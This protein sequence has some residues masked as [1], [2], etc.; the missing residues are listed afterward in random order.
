MKKTVSLLIL[1]FIIVAPLSS[2]RAGQI[3]SPPAQPRL[4]V[5]DAYSMIAAVNALRAAN[6][7]PA[8]TVNTTLMSLAQAH[9]DYMAA[10]GQVVHTDAGGLRPY[11]RALAAGYPLA[12]DL[13]L[14]GFY[15]ENIIMGQD[16]SV[17]DAVEAWQ[18]DTPHL[19]TM[20]APGLLEIGAGVSIVGGS[21]YYD[22]D[23]ARPTGSGQPQSYT[24]VAGQATEVPLNGTAVF[25]P[26]L[27]RTIIPSTPL[28]DGKLVHVVK[29][30]E[31]LWL[32]AITY[33]VKIADLRKLNGLTEAQDIYVGQKLLVKQA[34]T[35]LPPTD[36]A[37]ITSEPSI[38][39]VPSWTP[40]PTLTATAT[41]PVPVASASP[42]SS[43]M[44]LGAIVLA[45]LVLAGIFVLSG[46]RAQ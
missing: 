9:A 34:A 45:A 29:P 2:V 39:A 42:G 7:L 24:P 27:A 36:T 26:P 43:L 12:G 40:L 13:S 30:G 21:V 37:T 1:L 35:A 22:I 23:C 32:I 14:G 25:S 4:V 46:R 16:M 44:V 15:S 10:T 38:T 17:Q 11:Q 8:Y 20:L 31:T 41:T 18:G 33:G 3:F 5:T 19:T 28:S 6:G